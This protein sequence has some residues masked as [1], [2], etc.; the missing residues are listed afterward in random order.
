[1]S[2][3]ATRLTGIGARTFLRAYINLDI[4]KVELQLCQYSVMLGMFN[5]VQV[6]G[7]YFSV[8]Q[9]ATRAKKLI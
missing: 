9:A 1:M 3:E 2:Q 6:G 8:M 7:A 4:T 5:I